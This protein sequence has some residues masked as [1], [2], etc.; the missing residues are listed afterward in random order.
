MFSRFVLAA[1]V[2]GAVGTGAEL[3]LLTHSEDVWQ[4][5]PL[6]VI[7]AGL[8]SLVW[9]LVHGTL[10]SLRLFQ[11]LVALYM[12]AGVLG[13]VL[14]YQSNREFEL[15]MYP[16]MSGTELFW[17]TMTG[18]IPALAP[19]ALIQIGLIGLAYAHGRRTVIAQKYNEKALT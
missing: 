4:L 12:A 13:L 1:F 7:A 6:V 8:V 19:G 3:L 11:L 10:A 14:H 2:A 5:V 16:A 18:A 17:E 9:H 15:E